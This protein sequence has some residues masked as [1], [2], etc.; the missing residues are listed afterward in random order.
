MP[1]PPTVIGAPVMALGIF[2]EAALRAL[3]GGSGLTRP[4]A[5]AALLLWLA[6]ALLL[7]RSLARDGFATHSA[8]ALRSFGIGSWVAA[9]ALMVS[10][11]TLLWPGAAWLADFFAVLAGLLWLAFMPLALVNL[12]RL[13]APPPRAD[14]SVLLATVATQA[15]ALVLLDRFSED[16]AA[17]RSAV[18]LLLLLGSGCYLAGVFLV[19]WRYASRGWRLATDWT[20]GNCILHGALSISG[21]AAVTSGLVATSSLLL[22]W[23]ADLA[24]FLLVEVI[25]LARAVAR[26]RAFGLRRGLL[27][28][29]TSQWA[30]NF[31][32]GML[33]AFSQALATRLGSGATHPPLRLVLVAAPWVV[34]L[35]LLVELGLA[36]APA[37]RAR[38]GRAWRP[39]E[40]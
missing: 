22:F 23:R 15:L 1:W 20:N 29:H 14:G 33:Y 9:T 37:V 26:L 28:H 6:V 7:A 24:I 30:R 35:L 12:V 13:A 17:V 36:V 19:L 38:C 3:P 21:L 25:E 18:A 2:V 31:T 5:A 16:P 32:F 8:P 10:M 39:L 11:A 34:L 27:R 40:D 4:L